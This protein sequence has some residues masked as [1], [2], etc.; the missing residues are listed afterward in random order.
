MLNLKSQPE[1]ATHCYS[2]YMNF[3]KSQN[4]DRKSSC[5]YQELGVGEGMFMERQDRTK[6]Q[7]SLCGV[8]PK[9]PHSDSLTNMSAFFA[10]SRK[11]DHSQD[12]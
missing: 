3:Q 8:V 5:S 11:R 7:D 10:V 1:K 12:A 2:I 9:T 6:R 4:F